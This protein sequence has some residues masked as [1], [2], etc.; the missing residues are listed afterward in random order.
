MKKRIKNIFEVALDNNIKVLIL[1]TFGCGAFKNP[2]EIVATAFQ[3]VFYGISKEIHKFGNSDL[4]FLK[5]KKTNKYKGRQFSVLGDSISTLEGFQ[6][7]GYYVAGKSHDTQALGTI[8]W[9]PSMRYQSCD[10][11][12]K[13]LNNYINLPK[14]KGFLNRILKK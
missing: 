6:P 5:Y 13:D 14:P 7:Y 12:M 1:G 4:N 11:L 10:E 3:S 8:Q 2:L 9:D